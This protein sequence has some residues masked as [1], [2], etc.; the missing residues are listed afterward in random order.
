MMNK[1]PLERQFYG[2]SETFFKENNYTNTFFAR[3]SD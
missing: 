2:T 3:K 1:I